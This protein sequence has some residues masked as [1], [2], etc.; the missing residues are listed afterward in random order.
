M[1]FAGD[2]VIVIDAHKALDTSS[3]GTCAHVALCEVLAE[4]GFQ[5]ARRLVVLQL[6]GAVA[7][8]RLPDLCQP[9]FPA[10][11]STSLLWL[12]AFGNG[13]ATPSAAHQLWVPARLQQ[14]EMQ[15]RVAAGSGSAPVMD[16][17]R[18]EPG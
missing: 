9:P 7:R 5:D 15:G 13:A 8:M 16:Q 1:T 18:G 2:R 10:M 14:V 3:W 11:C 6:L 17:W 12:L 4:P